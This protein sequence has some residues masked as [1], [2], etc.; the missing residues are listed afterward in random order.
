YSGGTRTILPAGGSWQ[1]FNHTAGTGVAQINES[2]GALYANG[3]MTDGIYAALTGT[4]GSVGGSSLGAGLCAAGTASIAST[5][6]GMV[7]TTSPATYP[8][9]AFTWRAYV[10]AA[11][12]VTVKVC[13]GTAAAATP[14]ASAYNVRV[15]Q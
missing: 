6:T 11:G 3:D 2:N 8:G 4:T 9:D 1:V 5:T 13:N 14:T 7:A 12:T 10:S 15:V